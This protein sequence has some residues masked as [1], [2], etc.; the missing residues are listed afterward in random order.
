MNL[1][2]ISFFYFKKFIFIIF[3]LILV[4]EYA[5]NSLFNTYNQN[6]NNNINF[7]TNNFVTFLI[8]NVKINFLIIINNATLFAN[9]F[10]CNL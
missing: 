8:L 7:C 1:K 9:I 2:I 5:P 10:L 6:Q 4:E 3:L